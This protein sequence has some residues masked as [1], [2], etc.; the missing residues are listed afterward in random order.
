MRE[1]GKRYRLRKTKYEIFKFFHI[2]RKEV[3]SADIKECFFLFRPILF[4]YRFFYF[5]ISDF[6]NKKTLMMASALSYATVLGII[7]ITLVIVALSKG[8]LEDS[9]I[10]YTPKI[11][12]FVVAKLLPVFRD[13]P[14]NGN[15][16]QL[17]QSVQNYINFQ[18]IPTITN[19]NLHQIGL[20]GAIVLIVISLSLI[21]TIE[22][23]FNDIW[24]VVLKRSIC[25]LILRYWLV[26]ALFPAV[27][28]LILWITGF[29]VVHDM[30]KLRKTFWMTRIVSDQS[31]TV[32]ILWILF[33]TVYKII[34]NTRVKI[35][36]AIIGGIVGGTLWQINNTL[37]FLFVSNALRTHYIYG[38]LGIV[39]IFLISLFVGWLI[40][41]FGSHIAYAIQNLEFFRIR[42]LSTDLQPSD[43]QEIGVLCLAIIA[44]RQLE[45]GEPPNADEL[46]ELSGLPFAYFSKTI[47]EFAERKLIYETGDDSPRYMLCVPPD[48][49]RLKDIV[50]TAIGHKNDKKLPLVSNKHLWHASIRLCTNYR[51]SY[52]DTANPTLQKI[53][54]KLCGKVSKPSN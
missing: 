7:P 14:N 32:I 1:R 34:P 38:S 3:W 4:L 18:L 24:G 30:M 37:G 49:L 13:L 9:L 46:S 36:P 6:V 42:L 17:Y 31:F 19:L 11:I 47:N 16:E 51:N 40:V 22:K 5:V 45:H 2:M 15:G 52:T 8:F 48:K 26:I 21:R 39:P 28:L 41:L 10:S 25:K 35:M 23:A 50:D 53:A 20:Y 27:I 44:I 33:T 12:D 29:N 43:H 54:E